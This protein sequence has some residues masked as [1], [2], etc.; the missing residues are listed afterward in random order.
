MDSYLRNRRGALIAALALLLTGALSRPAWAQWADCTNEAAGNKLC[1]SGNVGIGTSTPAS[2]LQVV[3]SS[4]MTNAT[5]GALGAGAFDV[6][7]LTISDGQG[8]ADLSS[9]LSYNGSNWNLRNPANDGWMTAMNTS[10]GGTNLG[11]GWVIYHAASGANPATLQPFF[12]MTPTG[13]VGIGTTSPVHALQVVG[14]DGTIGA[15]QVIVSSTGADY[16]FAPNYR[17]A[18]LSEVGDYIMQKGHLP[19]IPSAKEVEAKGFNLGEMQTKLLAKIE[20]LTLHQ[21]ELEKQNR[22]L[23]ERIVK[24]EAH[25]AGSAPASATGADDAVHQ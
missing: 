1:A 3:G 24:L 18:P 9:N 23:Q 15:K 22:E 7:G 17:L 20:E 25:D 6:L 2:P 4:T 12:F 21:I 11:A 16:V 19:D 13:N 10:T 14:G 8:F 5:F